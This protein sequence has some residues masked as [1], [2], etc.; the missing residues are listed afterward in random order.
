M[1]AGNLLRGFHLSKN[2]KYE[3]E[4]YGYDSSQL[5]TFLAFAA[6]IAIVLY[7]EYMGLF[8]FIYSENTYDIPIRSDRLINATATP[9]SLVGKA[10]IDPETLILFFSNHTFSVLVGR[11]FEEMKSSIFFNSVAQICASIPSG[12][13][14]MILDER[15][16]EDT[17]ACLTIR[18][19]SNESWVPESCVNAC[20]EASRSILDCGWQSIARVNRTCHARTM[21]MLVPLKDASSSKQNSSLISN[22]TIGKFRRN[23]SNITNYAY[24]VEAFC[25]AC[26][27][28][29]GDVN[30]ACEDVMMNY[31]SIDVLDHFFTD[32]DYWC[33]RDD[34]ETETR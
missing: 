12:E 29:V 28:D 16:K 20:D 7:A 6:T 26:V 8:A 13:S 2:V 25:S 23:F 27:S 14:D 11:S 31:D 18:R 34:R 33:N 3:N 4:S 9:T 30:G 10:F 19:I 17:D 15:S 21:S 24:H 5:N 22:P 32:L 1:E